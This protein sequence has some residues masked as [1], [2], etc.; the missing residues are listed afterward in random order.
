MTLPGL[1]GKGG[2][3]RS[4]IPLLAFL[5]AALVF[6]ASLAVSGRQLANHVRLEATGHR[7]GFW[8]AGQALLEAARLRTDVHRHAAGVPGAAAG[9][10][11]RFEILWSRILALQGGDGERRSYPALDAVRATLPEILGQLTALEADLPGVI[12]R[13]TGALAR[14]ELVLADLVS[15]LNVANRAL[16]QDR[17]IA[18]EAATLGLSRLQT[19]F[20]ASA[21][22]LIVSASLLCTVLFWLWRRAQATL[23]EAEEARAHAGRSERLLRVVVDSLPLMVSAHDRD[24]R[25]VMANAD[26]AE[27]HRTTEQALLGRSVAEATGS[28][29]DE[30]DLAAALAGGGQ[31]PFRETA[32]PGPDGNARTLLTS[33][34]PVLDADGAVTAVARISLDITERKA[35]EEQIRYI[36]EHDSLTG[37]A[38]R[39]LFTQRLNHALNA[40]GRVALHLIDI[41][42]FKDVNDSLG[43]AAGDA[44][45]LTAT[46]RMRGC[47]RPEDVLARLGGDEFAVVQPAIRCAEEAEAVAARIVRALSAPYAIEGALVKAGASVGIAIGG[48]AEAD[49]PRLLQRADIALHAAKAAGRRQVRTFS[50][51]MDAALGEQRRLEQDVQKALAESAFHFA[52]QPKFRLSDLGFAGCEA[53][54]RWDHRLRG[55]VPPGIFIPAAERAGLSVPL[56]RHTLHAALRQQAAWRAQDIDIAV[57]V[58]LSARH[59]VSGQAVELVRDA[60]EAENGVPERLEI[61]VTEDVFIRDPGAAA[62]T[63]EALRG[64][65]VRLALDDFGTGYASLGYL[66]QLPFDVIKL[67][68]SFVA[69]LGSSTRTERIVDAI[70]RIAHGLGAKLVAEG[71]ENAVQLARLREIGCDEGQGYLL[72]RPM[73][74]EALSALA[75]SQ[76]L[77]AAR[78]AAGEPLAAVF[79]AE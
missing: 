49:G 3:S 8:E 52:F 75:R 9:I 10:P 2:W 55:P 15:R 71:V 43:H 53:L 77:A 25:F 29:E 33:A 11:Q 32:A 37:L 13:D 6:V 78:V 19:T 22:G 30:A 56:A 70:T 50:A 5:L 4:T 34:A 65:G 46:S 38:N 76:G 27:F 57:A 16:H 79:A 36:A 66:Q 63:L 41:D 14:A 42:D 40:G 47:L 21:L 73:A 61:E 20:A 72:G 67:D 17:Q 51:A 44:L 31:L 26:F 12:G 45:L 39:L 18:S 23:H 24:G 60:L 68:R 69:G 48:T 54:L 59:I 28:A 7:I 35:A 58:N 74:P 62:T 1:A 64:L